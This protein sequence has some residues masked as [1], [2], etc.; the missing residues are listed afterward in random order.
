MRGAGCEVAMRRRSRGRGG[1]RVATTSSRA[2]ALL[3]CARRYPSRTV[4]TRRQS[5]DARWRSGGEP[6]TPAKYAL[7]GGGSHAPPP[8]T[9]LMGG[10]G[11]RPPPPNCMWG[12]YEYD[13]HEAGD[14]GRQAQ[15]L[16]PLGYLGHRSPKVS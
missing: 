5:R 15:N 8:Y 12:G 7:E 11:D 6:A 13:I 3:A 2:A 14:K 9:R 10:G 16:P 1:W 4:S